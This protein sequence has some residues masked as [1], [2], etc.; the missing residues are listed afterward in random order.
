MLKTSSFAF[1]ASILKKWRM[2]TPEST[3]AMMSKKGE[4]V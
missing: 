2:R 4:I 3:T 1:S